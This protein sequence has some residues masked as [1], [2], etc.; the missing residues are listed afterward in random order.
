MRTYNQWRPT[1]CEP[2]RYRGR[3]EAGEL[4][5]WDF[6]AWRVIE[7]S[8]IP[9]DRW[10]D[11]ERQRWM[12]VYRC[13]AAKAPYRL[14]I[15]RDR[16]P[17]SDRE[18]K[19]VRVPPGGTPFVSLLP[20]HYAT[21]GRCGDVA[22][23]REVVAKETSQAAA[24]R[25]GRYEL[26]GVCPACEEPVTTRQKSLTFPENVEVLTGPPVTFH[27]RYACRSSAVAYEKRWAAA[28]PENR[29]TILSCR[30][31]VTAHGDGTY[32]CTEFA[33]C[34]GPTA[35]HPGGSSCREPECHTAG[36]VHLGMLRGAQLRAPLT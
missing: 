19:S 14:R 13:D 23:C 15:R 21:C 36:P 18:E 2:N 1:S 35:S 31:H 20:E 22:P 29:R 7:V 25:M 6:D 10:T 28:D 17:A 5:A 34:P 12:D 4:I 3:I 8:D 16:A 24:K 33:L 9:A 26:E 27:L 11:A 30:G 32:E